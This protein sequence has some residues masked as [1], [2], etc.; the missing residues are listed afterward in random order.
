MQVFIN[1][2]S[3]FFPNAPVTNDEIEKVLG[4]VR[5]KAS[6]SKS[7]VLSSNLIKTRY[8]AIDPQTRKP[9][10]SN[11]QITA[12]AVSKI[13]AENPDLKISDTKLLCCGTTVADL[14]VPGHGQMVQGLLK[15]FSGEVI[16]NSGVC[17]SSMAAFKTA[18]L[19]VTT[20]DTEAAIVTGSEVSSKFMRSEFF[21][22]ESEE[23]VEDK[24]T[25]LKKNPMLAFEHE[26]L[27]WMLSDGAGAIY[28]SNAPVTG[29]TNLKINWVEGRSYANEEAVCMFAGG[30]REKDDTVTSWKDLRLTDD[31]QKN[32]YAMNFRQDIRQLR[33]KAPYYTIERAFA[34][35]K[36]K[37]G[38]RPG[39]YNWFVPHYSS[40]FFREILREN[41]KKLD[42]EIPENRWFTTL[43][44]TGNIGSASVFVFIDQLIRTQKLKPGEKILCYIPESARFSVYY[45]ELEVV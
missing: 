7:I 27:R 43:S 25:E 21:E 22:S 38:L 20:G 10:H 31:V 36:K 44:E 45:V 2:T 16:S 23:T 39:D 40:N 12:E 37:R 14:I 34:D 13:F 9:T 41:L 18:F 33:E 3:S 42:F 8:Y 5:G 30:A 32:A 29:K 35:I 19:S 15:D 28:M 26:F 24:I 6:R 11:A 4:E 17:C 1:A